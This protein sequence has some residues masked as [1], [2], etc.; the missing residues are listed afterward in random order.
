MKMV[1]VDMEGDQSVQ[2]KTRWPRKVGYT[3]KI[4][5]KRLGGGIERKNCG[6]D[7]RFWY[8]NL[9][10]TDM[11]LEK[12]EHIYN[13]NRG[14]G[15]AVGNLN[16]FINWW[17]MKVDMFTDEDYKKMSCLL[18]S[19]FYAQQVV[20]EWEKEWRKMEKYLFKTT[21]QNSLTHR[22]PCEEYNCHECFCLWS[23][24]S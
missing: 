10:I 22:L 18:I 3:E 23:W 6:T 16:S 4:N 21:F 7:W 9:F 20:E 5:T 11:M 19:Q 2:E 12:Q 14:Y 24:T 15:K 1:F 8:V 17:S 13:E